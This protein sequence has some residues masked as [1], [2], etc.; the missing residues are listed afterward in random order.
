MKLT[1]LFEA[2]VSGSANIIKAVINSWSPIQS[3]GDCYVYY[4]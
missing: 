1:G 2:G 4:Y 3:I